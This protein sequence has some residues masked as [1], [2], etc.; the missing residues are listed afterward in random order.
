MSIGNTINDFISARELMMHDLH[1]RFSYDEFIELLYKDLEYIASVMMDGVE[2]YIDMSETEISRQIYNNLKMK[3]Y[4]AELDSDKNGNADISVISGSYKWISEA[5]IFGGANRYGFDHINEGFLQLTT[6]YSKGESHAYHGGLFIYIKPK[7]K[8]D[9]EKSVMDGWK[10]MIE[11]NKY[12]LNNLEIDGHHQNKRYLTTK[13]DHQVSGY[14]YV[15]KHIPICLLH[16]PEDK[17][18]L[19]AEKY[20]LARKEYRNN[21]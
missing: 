12:E 6:R 3:N 5:K 10:A 11:S 2:T 8:N 20:A 16:L 18:G 14:P 15:V 4:G 1:S 21:S 7:G 13:H 19:K 17:S 9:T